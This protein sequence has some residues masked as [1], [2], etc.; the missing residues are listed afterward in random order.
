[1]EKKT[2]IKL[3]SRQRDILRFFLESDEYR[4]LAELA[5][6]LNVSVR[7]L[8]RELNELEPVAE[9]WGVRFLKKSG[10]GL[11]LEGEPERK[12]ELAA[13]LARYPAYKIYSPEERQ[14]IMKQ[15][16]LSCKEPTKLYAFSRK[17]NVT[18]STVSCDLNR[19]E[20]WLGK[21]GIRLERKP[22]LGIYIEGNEK[23]IRAAMA[24]L[25]Y[26]TVTHE[27]LMELLHLQSG[28][29]R[30]NL[31]LS[32]RNRLLNF[33]DPQWLFQIEQVIQVSQRK[34]EYNMAGSA[35]VG[36]VVHLALALQRIQKNE[37]IVI[38]RDILQRLRGTPEFELAAELAADLSDKLNVTIPESEIGYITM[39]LLG[40]R[41]IHMFPEK[42]SHSNVAAYVSRMIAIVEREL[43]LNLESDLSLIENLTAHLASAVQRIELGMA[44]RNPLLEHV[45]QEYPDI[46]EATRAASRYLEQ[47]LGVPVPEEEIGYLAMHF[48]TAVLRKREKGIER[49]RVLLVCASGIGAS[50]LLSTQLERKL[51]QIHI[52][53]TISLFHLEE[54]L[55]THPPVDLIISTLSVQVDDVRVA[56]VN[57]FLSDEDIELIKRQLDL[58]PS[59]DHLLAEEQ[60]DIDGT[61]SKV[62]NFGK[63]L[64]CLLHAVSVTEE[65]APRNK[66]ELI[67][68]VIEYVSE[69]YAVGDADKLLRD[70]NQREEYGP[71]MVEKD[72]VALLH[73]RSEGIEEMCVCVVRLGADVNWATGGQQVPIRTVVT[74]MGPL[75]VPEEYYELVSEITFALIEEE[76]IALLNEGTPEQIKEGIRLIFKKGYLKLAGDILR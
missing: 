16:I 60:I 1:M 55:R 36:F 29:R 10:V 42:R 71:V 23:Q 39:H 31:E 11:M 74:V 38:E 66:R 19:I 64:R 53:D 68:R 2:G 57:P 32:I 21:Y 7:T 4:T 37:E 61:V 9:Q 28:N 56:V 12:D 30:E 69:H 22:G 51:P 5:R 26:E 18:E 72:K 24:D 73:C 50:R 25:L 70:L 13:E 46:F 6:H 45:K 52:M 65:P 14:L 40:A 44:I 33:I 15:M 41:S 54:W 27:Q 17:L 47:Q 67:A 43:K 49:R 48:G 58:I 76:F 3:N 75:R 63:A 35:Y 20:P 62:E 8:Q 34:W 59:Q